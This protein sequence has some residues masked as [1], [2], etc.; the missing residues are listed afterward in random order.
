LGC[1]LGVVPAT[2]AGCHRIAKHDFPDIPDSRKNA[3]SYAMFRTDVSSHDGIGFQ[4]HGSPRCQ[5]KR[6]H[7][8]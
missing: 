1:E 4:F 5:T 3:I 6:R 7:P 2:L 8:S